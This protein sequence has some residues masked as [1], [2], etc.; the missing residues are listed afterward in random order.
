VYTYS[1]L[2]PSFLLL[3]LQLRFLLIAPYAL[4]IVPAVRMIG[5]VMGDDETTHGED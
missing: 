5:L 1:E 4:D 2:H 3:L